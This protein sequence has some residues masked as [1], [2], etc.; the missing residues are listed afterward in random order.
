MDTDLPLVSIIIPTRNCAATIERCLRSIQA[1]TYTNLEII[2]VDND[3]D[4]AT[5]QIAAEYARVLSAGPERSAQMNVGAKYAQGDYIYRVD[6]DFELAPTVVETCVEIMKQ[7]QLDALA[8]PNRS[9]GKG[10]WSKVRALERDTYVNDSLIV[11]ARFWK[12]EVFEAIGGFDPALVACEDYDVH[13]RLLARGYKV[14]H[15][16]EI[17]GDAAPA[18]THLGEKDNLWAYAVQSFYYGPS[19]LRYLQKHPQRGT[20][21]MFPLR[22]AYLRHWQALLRHP[23]LLLGLCV[24]KFVQ[25][26]ATLAGIVA[27]ALGFVYVERNATKHRFAL[28]AFRSFLLVLAAMWSLVNFLP[29]FNIQI[30]AI[31]KVGIVFGGILVWQGIGRR[32]ARHQKRAVPL[33]LPDVAL[34]FLPLFIMLFVNTPEGHKIIPK[35]QLQLCTL[36]L[37][38]SAAWLFYLAKPVAKRS[39]YVAATTL[40]ALGCVGF[41]IVFGLR[42]QRLLQTFSLD[43]YEI[44]PYE[45]ALWLGVQGLTPLKATSLSKALY[46]SIY[47]KS[48]FAYDPAP[49]LLLFLPIYALRLG[50]PLFLLISQS[51]AM[52]L[53]A[54][55]LYRLAEGKIGRFS[56]ALVALAFLVH[57]VTLRVNS[58]TF[59]MTAFAAPLLLFALDAYRRQHYIVYC[60]LILLSLT[61]GLEVGATVAALGLYLWHFKDDS[62]YGSI[63]LGMGVIWVATMVVVFIPF[64][65]GSIE[66]TLEPYAM[67]RNVDVVTHLTSRI[68]RPETAHY[69]GTLLASLGFM[70]LLDAPLLLLALPRIV[71]NL[72]ATSP[73]YTSLNGWYE[74]TVLPFL[75][76]ATVHGI[77]RLEALLKER[78]KDSLKFAAGVF[79]LGTSLITSTFLGPSL[80]Q[81]FQN[82]HPTP[83]HEQGQAILRQIPPEAS[84]ATQNAFGISLAHRQNLTLLPQIK[85]PD[86]ILFDVFHP[87]YD[88]HSDVYHET[89]QRAFYN[90][91]YGLRDATNGYLLYERGLDFDANLRVLA[92]VDAPQITYARTVELSATIAYLGFDLS[93]TQLRVN[94]PLYITHYWK[95][96]APAQK[97]YLLFLAGPGFRHF[98]DMALGLFPVYQWQVG[99]IVRHEQQIRLPLLPNGEHYEIVVGLWYDEG[100]PGVLNETQFLGEDVIRI[101]NIMAKDGHYTIKP[102]ANLGF[103]QGE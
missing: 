89:L 100:D 8:V 85:D 17:L 76:L 91:E 83:H 42:S 31:A 57:F 19:I 49:A 59:Q 90:P 7:H 29:R 55:A 10:Y 47:G 9:V 72:V 28:R 26:T 21:Q 23:Y 95:S 1:Q 34:A 41:I 50:S 3:S 24:L 35:L 79:V 38:G 51:I 2:V 43:A 39:V 18:E 92:L 15:L 45:Q 82:L 4:D 102:W 86:F 81:D 101:A 80:W 84:I 33:V 75:F 14:G 53:T 98:E 96:L 6:G 5:P 74:F 52:V 69:V 27:Q 93:T 22:P 88:S 103:G 25:Y 61:C 63:T 44:A 60:T 64:F 46:T 73:H 36:A 37:A 12:R 54:L 67:P 58:V 71:L 32:R 99:D 20:R 16:A 11:A 68:V 65:G 70:P 40:F 66:Q 62:F 78:Q 56:S 94:D 87:Q 30:G 13:N 97:P 77:Q 48:L